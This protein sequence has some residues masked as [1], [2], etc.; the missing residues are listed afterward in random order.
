MGQ[1]AGES[2]ADIAVMATSHTSVSPHPGPL[3]SS[4]MGLPL[5]LQVAEREE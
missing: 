5:L 2:I 1:V 3:R 4:S